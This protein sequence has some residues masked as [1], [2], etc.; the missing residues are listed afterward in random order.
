MATGL[1]IIALG[2]TTRLFPF[3]SK[4]DKT[5]TGRIRLGLATDTYDAEGTPTSSPSSDYPT[6]ERLAAAMSAFE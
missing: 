3:Y 1:I 4:R 5:Y 2:H 6:S